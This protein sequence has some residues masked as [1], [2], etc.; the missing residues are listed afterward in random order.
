MRERSGLRRSFLTEDYEHR[1]VRI[2]M[3]RDNRP[4]VLDLVFGW[5]DQP[6]VRVPEF[7]L[8]AI[9]ADAGFNVL[10]PRLLV[11][12]EVEVRIASLAVYPHQFGRDL[13]TVVLEIGCGLLRL[14]NFLHGLAPV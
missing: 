8:L 14:K 9:D 4:S 10:G 6:G 7:G 13:R 11:G 1:S 5:L 2:Q 3:Q 12:H